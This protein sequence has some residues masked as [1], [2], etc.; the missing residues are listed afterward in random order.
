MLQQSVLVPSIPYEQLTTEE[1]EELE[2]TEKGVSLSRFREYTSE[3]LL[4]T[5][6]LLQEAY[7]NEGEKVIYDMLTAGL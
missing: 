3:I 1:I 4:K 5:Y 6:L 2:T 7:K